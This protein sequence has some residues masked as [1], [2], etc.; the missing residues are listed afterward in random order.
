[1]GSNKNKL[2]HR[3]NHRHVY[4][5]KKLP[6]KYKKSPPLHK[7][8][9]MTLKN[10]SRI[11]NLNKLQQY[12]DDL[13]AHAARCKGS[14]LLYGETR[15]GLASILRGHCSVCNHTIILESSQKV[16]GPKGY[17]QWECNLA[18]VWGEMVTGGGHSR[19]K[20][21]LGVI[22]IPV[23]T[24]ASFINVERA[25][26]EQWKHELLKSMIEAGKEEKRLAEERGDFHEGI[27]AITVVVDGGWSKR[28][29]KHSYNAKSGVAIIIGKETGKLLYIGVRNKY[30][31]ACAK[32]VPKEKHQCFKNWEKSS[33][34][35][36]SDIILDG[37]LEA[38]HVHGVRYIRFVGD[39]DSSVHTTLLQ[40]VPGWGF[41]IRKLECANHACKCYRGALEKIVQQNASYKGTGGLTLKMRKRLVSA[42][43]CAIRMRSKNPDRK[44]A[45][46]LLERD[47]LNG[48]WHCFG[49]HDRCSSDFCSAVQPSDQHAA[50]L[51]SSSSEDENLCDEDDTDDFIGMFL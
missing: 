28:S 23:M 2:H 5:K 40:S 37:F 48:P 50:P 1:M 20:E 51:T 42:A 30:C 25:I 14:I 6:Y 43:R 15:Q 4:R 11:I 34:E 16:R 21:T 27:P 26:G 3:N 41:A 12:T 45:A 7:H 49:I 29:H 22:G 47:L 18:A 44:K 38:E 32:N 17:P 13:T 35:M 10:G 8:L 31:R 46:K 33:S 9:E 36:E 24:K 39:G 19:I